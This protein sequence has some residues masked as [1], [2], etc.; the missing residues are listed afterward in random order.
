MGG[1]GGHVGAAPLLW[2]AIV[3]TLRDIPR[4]PHCTTADLVNVVCAFVH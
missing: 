2:E 1:P 3:L 4:G